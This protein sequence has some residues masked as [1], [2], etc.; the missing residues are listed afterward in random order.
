MERRILKYGEL[1]GKGEA[2]RTYEFEIT[3]ETPDSYDT[4]FKS[5][6][7]DMTRYEKNPIVA[8]NHQTHSGDPDHIIG[9]S[10]LRKEGDRWIATLTLE[11]EGE[12][13]IADKVARKIDSGVIKGASVGAMV[14]DWRRGDKSQGEDPNLIYFTRQELAEWSVVTIPAN[15][16]ALKR[17]ADFINQIKEETKPES[18]ISDNTLKLQAQRFRK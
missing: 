4:V 10:T 7:W 17:N 15:K 12:N 14:F 13:P 5:D 6:G 11:A 9:T 18:R 8:Y 3:N 1:R 2:P 16:E